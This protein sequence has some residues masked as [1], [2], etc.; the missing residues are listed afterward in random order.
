MSTDMSEEGFAA[1][2]AM[3]N[4]ARGMVRAR[5]AD[6]RAELVRSGHTETAIDEA[7]KAWASYE[8]KKQWLGGQS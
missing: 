6:V 4:I 2:K 3:M 8:A 7:V 5:L 1:L